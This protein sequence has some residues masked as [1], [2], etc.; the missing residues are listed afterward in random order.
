[1]VEG[2][3]EKGTVVELWLGW[4]VVE[5]GGE[6]GTVVELWLGWEVVEGGG[7]KGTVGMWLA[8]HMAEATAGEVQPP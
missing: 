8:A 5:G 6:K 3:G 1:V 7:E 2:G 4:E